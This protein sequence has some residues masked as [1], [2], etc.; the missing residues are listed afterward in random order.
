[1]NL[2]EPTRWAVTQKA[3]LRVKSEFNLQKQ[4]AEFADFYRS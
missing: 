2:D 4:K 1:M 3:M